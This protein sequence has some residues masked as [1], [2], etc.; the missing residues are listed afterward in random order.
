MS[1]PRTPPLEA[2]STQLPGGRANDNHVLGALRAAASVS[3]VYATDSPTVYG[4]MIG[5]A[6][7][8]TMRQPYSATSNTTTPFSNYSGDTMH[9]LQLSGKSREIRIVPDE[10]IRPISYSRPQSH[11]YIPVCDANLREEY[12]TYIRVPSIQH[13]PS[14][15]TGSL[16]SAR[17][18]REQF[19]RETPF[20]EK[21]YAQYTRPDLPRPKSSVNQK[22]SMS[23]GDGGDDDYYDEEGDGNQYFQKRVVT[24][25]TR[26]DVPTQPT[27]KKPTTPLDSRSNKV[28]R[29]SYEFTPSSTPPLSK[30]ELSRP[31]K[32]ESAT[33]L[34]GKVGLSNP[35]ALAY[36]SA[37]PTDA[38]S[39]IQTRT[40][41]D[42]NEIWQQL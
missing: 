33:D 8:R 7:S 21:S 15:E 40:S 24:T 11:D 12:E 25:S 35:S 39:S 14:Y 38:R 30:N 26:T 23:Y 10:E 41:M 16:R 34:A 4:G 9:R 27:Y 32:K 6:G 1:I 29:T 3:N 36:T 2:A 13:Q 31:S 19:A 42:M 5:D 22:G 20:S 37:K 17:S 28:D 18:T